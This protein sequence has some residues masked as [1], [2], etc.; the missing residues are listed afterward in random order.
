MQRME[1]G[2]KEGEWKGDLGRRMERG[3]ERGM[4]RRWDILATQGDRIGRRKE[5]KLGWREKVAEKVR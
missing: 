1:G 2:E 3:G 4:E 5:G